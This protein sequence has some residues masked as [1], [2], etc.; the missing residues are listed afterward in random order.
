M[1]PDS[2]GLPGLSFTAALSRD[3]A[4]EAAS[5]PPLPASRRA[6]RA[7]LSRRASYL[8]ASPSGWAPWPVGGGKQPGRPAH[9]LRVWQAAR[10]L[11]PLPA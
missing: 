4:E 6:S 8:Q 1:D 7:V 2:Q 5:P 10:A 3:K 9:R 11:P